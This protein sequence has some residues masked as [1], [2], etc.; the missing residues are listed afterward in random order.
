MSRTAVNKA[1]QIVI[2]GFVLLC[3]GLGAWFF[4]QQEARA[5]LVWCRPDCQGINLAGAKLDELTI[6]GVHFRAVYVGEMYLRDARV[7][8]QTQMPDNWWLIWEIVNDKSTG[9]DLQGIVLRGVNLSAANLRGANL[10]DADLSKTN[11]QRASLKGA[12]LSGANLSGT[13]L[14]RANLRDTSLD[15]ANLYAAKVDY[16]TQLDKKWRLVWE[17]VNQEVIGRDLHG[18]D[19][20]GANLE[21]SNLSQAN[22]SRANLS[23]TNLR[24]TNLR[25]ANLTDANLTSAKYNDNT[26]WPEGFTPPSDAI[27]V[28]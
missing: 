6:N 1:F 7:D 17:V 2:G 21:G 15:G 10:S 28:D 25:E 5:R 9:R 20:S 27:K 23:Q 4:W 26:Q 16:G 18:V 3:L 19:L 14:R 24:E 8:T 22:L 13:D 11:L 12:N